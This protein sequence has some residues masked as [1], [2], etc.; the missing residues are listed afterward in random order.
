[1]KKTNERPP[2]LVLSNSNIA[3]YTQRKETLEA[4]CQIYDVTVSS[5]DDGFLDELV[6]LGLTFIPANFK[7]R[8]INIFSEFFLMMHYFFLL[9]K[10]KPVA[11]LTFSIKP[12]I[13]GNLISRILRIPT[14][15]SI[16]GLGDTFIKTGILSRIVNLLYR[17]S[18]KKTKTIVFENEEDI[19]IF[20]SLKIIKNQD[21]L[22]FPGAGVNLSTFTPE[23]YPTS[24]KTIFLYI[25][26]YMQT[27]GIIELLQATRRLKNVYLNS[28]ELHLMGFAEEDLEDE[29][30]SAI[31]DGIIVN[32]GFQKDVRPFIK[33]S[34]VII[35]P[36]YKEGMAN[37]LL[38]GG[39][40]ARPLI[41]TNVSG[42]REIID[43]G[44]TGFLCEPRD[45]LSLYTA[46]EKFLQL[47]L[48][49][50]KSMG[51]QSRK[52]IERS[53]DRTI[54]VNRTLENLQK[55]RRGL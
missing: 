13:Y 4:L 20:K 52:K 6:S 34:H 18:L 48:S 53:F 19:N 55:I 37:V 9:L 31:S 24:E 38:E 50:K 33:E 14:F 36:S 3:L 15:T 26:R 23:P 12:T 39:A 51:L 46:M 45:T 2:I 1:M 8:Q 44:T 22:L 41:A 30:Q 49:Q 17:F 10:L 16:T 29:V 7:R 5:N 43:N 35:L 28:F 32:L 54:V 47:D 21:V 42:C 25:G 27:K 40:M 11:V